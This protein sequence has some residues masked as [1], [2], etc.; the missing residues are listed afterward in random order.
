MAKA[1]L[2]LKKKPEVKKPKLI[3]TKKKPYTPKNKK[4]IA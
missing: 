1:K 4:N 3:L 2:V